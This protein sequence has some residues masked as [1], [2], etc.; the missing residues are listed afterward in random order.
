MGIRSFFIK[1]CPFTVGMLV[2]ALVHLGIHVLAWAIIIH[3]QKLRWKSEESGF[4]LLSVLAANLIDLDH[5]LADPIYD[6]DRCSIGFHPLHSF[7]AMPFYVAGLFWRTRYFA[8]GVI[9]HLVADGLDC[10]L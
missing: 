3:Y 10:L 4:I 6:P 2:H 9:L 8:L 7:W 1:V 5:L